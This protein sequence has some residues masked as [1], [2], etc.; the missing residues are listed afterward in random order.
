MKMVEE[1]DEKTLYSRLDDASDD[2]NDD[3]DYDNDDLLEEV[4]ISV[5]A[6]LD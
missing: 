5:I 2:D 4:S 6:S 1:I 3:N